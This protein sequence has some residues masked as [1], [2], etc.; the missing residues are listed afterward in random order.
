MFAPLTEAEQATASEATA[1]PEPGGWHPIQ[2]VPQCGPK[3][4][5]HPR[6]GKPSAL[7]HF[8]DS[9]GRFNKSDGGKEILP[10]TFWEDGAGRQRWRWKAF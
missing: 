2:P 3:A 9:E 7:W 4:E 1:A 8:R 5:P 10:L 6:L